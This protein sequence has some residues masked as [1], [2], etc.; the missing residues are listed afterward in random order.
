MSC[1]IN[2]SIATNVAWAT[3]TPASGASSGPNDRQRHVVSY[4]TAGLTPG[5]YTGQITVTADCANGN[6][7]PAANSPQT[8]SLV[9]DVT[10][11]PVFDIG[12]L[13]RGHPRKHE[14]VRRRE[15]PIFP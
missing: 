14:F 10:A 7:P 15:R 1:P 2:Y 5:R 4:N 3:V 12:D 13:D 8:I 6:V 9:L 11:I